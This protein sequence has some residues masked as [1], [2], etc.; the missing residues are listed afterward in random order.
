MNTIGG[1]EPTTLR[2]LFEKNF[3]E[4]YRTEHT[5]AAEEEIT[6]AVN[7]YLNGIFKEGSSVFKDYTSHTM[8]IF[9]MERGAGASNL[10]MRFNLS[11]VTPGSVTMMKDITDQN[12]KELTG[13]DTSLI[14]YPYQIFY[15]DKT[16]TWYPLTEATTATEKFGVYYLNPKRKADFYARYKP[17]NSSTIYQNVFFLYPGKDVSI[18]FPD[19]T[20]EYFIVECGV[21]T[22]VYNPPV[23]NSITAE[24]PDRE[25]KKLIGEGGDDGTYKQYVIAQQRV[26]DRPTVA[27]T[28]IV[29]TGKL[30]TLTVTKKVYDSKGNEVPED[31]AKFS[32]RLY[33]SDAG[34]VRLD[35]S[36]DPE[37][38]EVV[39]SDELK[40]AYRHGYYVVSPNGKLCQWDVETQGFTETEHDQTEYAALGDDEKNRLTFESS[41]N[42]RIDNI[43]AGYSVKIPNLMVG[44]Y[45]MVEEREADNTL[46]YEL[47]GYECVLKPDDLHDTPEPSYTVTAEYYGKSNGEWQNYGII[48]KM[49][50]QSELL[51]KNK[52][53]FGLQAEKVW[54]DTDYVAEHEKVYFAVYDNSSGTEE[55]V[56]DTVRAITPDHMS[57]QYYI[58]DVLDG[59]TIENYVIREVRLTGTPTVDT[60][61]FAVTGYDSITPISNNGTIHLKA[62]DGE[63]NSL[64]AKEGSEDTG[65][66]YFV[67][68]TKAPQ[69][70][71]PSNSK[72]EIVTNTREGGIAIRLFQW[73]TQDSGLDQVPLANG[74]FT[75]KKGDTNVAK[76]K[77][78]S[79]TNGL[80]T[81]LYTP[82]EDG[83]YDL[84]E[85]LSP[86]SFI[87]MPE[88]ITFRLGQTSNSE[89]PV[90]ILSQP[91]DIAENSGE[92][93]PVSERWAVLRV[94]DVEKPDPAI[95]K[96][97]SVIDIYN[98]PFTLQVV[99]KKANAQEP[100]ADA[101]FQLY[102]VRPDNE[103]NE[104]KDYV[105][106]NWDGVSDLVSGADGVIPH[107]DEELIPMKYYLTETRAPRKYNKLTEDV[108]LTVNE[109]GEI[110]CDER[111]ME[112]EEVLGE[113]NVL[114]VIFTISIP[115]TPANVEYYF[116]IEKLILVDQNA[117][118]TAHD[119]DRYAG[120]PYQKFVFLVE[121]LD[122]NM[123]TESQF[124][125]TMNCTDDITDTYTGTLK[126]YGGKSYD[127]KIVTC[128]DGYKYPAAVWKGLQTIKVSEKGTYRIT[129][130][131][132]WSGTDYEF[133]EGSNVYHG[134]DGG[135]YSEGDSVILDVTN[136]NANY[137][138]GNSSDRPTASF[139][140]SETEYAYLS[141][142]A[143]AENIIKKN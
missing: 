66:Q 35:E 130:V 129:E 15:K 117:H 54:S 135:G 143:Y 42:G 45:F 76:E 10:H 121:K 28:N 105:P 81:V 96:Y 68:Y 53:G 21:N 86:R 23:Y 100:L 77:Y 50:T 103:G 91:S 99:K 90:V 17:T 119:D 97:V 7:E 14:K 87:G 8:H 62:L 101:H 22:D 63:G 85:S 82:S 137:A 142:Q 71:L 125:V 107:I 98:K 140:N 110:T 111:Y 46:G 2:A 49:K 127:N 65:F 78:T 67:E 30:K 104:M 122:S 116:D 112:R 132:G 136:A 84:T 57:V 34:S 59:K 126:S 16:D 55:L 37:S 4:R 5:D 128:A 13:I 52:K 138:S 3:T 139:T 31:D 95:D 72:K 27:L 20:I 25:I 109:L 19:D 114:R 58:D 108:E 32:F 40:L 94:P 1:N 74:V 9:Y 83:T 120:D 33:L 43:P 12:E 18:V 93:K 75:L 113:D 115:N 47:I 64:S 41:I 24:E 80:V 124:F 69:G 134:F 88:G 29:D 26:S 89:A 131:V 6:N 79:D 51:I 39:A 141:S 118:E 73:G 44:T 70:K 102:K 60:D 48:D 11:Y 123:Q 133:W 92:L 36:S 38:G 106:V 56:P 61:T